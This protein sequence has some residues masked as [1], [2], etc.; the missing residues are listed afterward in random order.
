MRVLEFAAHIETKGTEKQF[1]AE[2]S[3]G[4]GRQ[5]CELNNISEV[6]IAMTSR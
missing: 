3:S 2:N 4:K 1:W 5:N 6:I